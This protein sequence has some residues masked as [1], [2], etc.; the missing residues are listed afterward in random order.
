MNYKTIDTISAILGRGEGIVIESGMTVCTPEMPDVKMYLAG[1]VGYHEDLD[2]E[3]SVYMP[4]LN[5]PIKVTQS[6]VLI[7]KK[8]HTIMN[9]VRMAGESEQVEID[10]KHKIGILECVESCVDIMQR[11]ESGRITKDYICYKLK[12]VKKDIHAERF[13]YEKPNLYYRTVS[14]DFVLEREDR[15]YVASKFLCLCRYTNQVT[16]TLSY[17]LFNPDNV[18]LLSEKTK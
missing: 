5:G 10:A 8:T 3:C 1:Y 4:D 18:I 7:G 6:R 2:L 15:V 14:E 13:S 16:G 11:F 17:N 9:S 12:S